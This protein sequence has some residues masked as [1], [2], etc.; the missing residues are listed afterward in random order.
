M[1]KYILITFLLGSLNWAQA[2]ELGKLTVDKI[3]R[4]PV[5]MGTSPSGVQWSA[6]S[7]TVYFQWNP[8]GASKSSWYYITTANTNPQKLSK[9]AEIALPSFRGAFNKAKTQKL[10]E[11]NGDIFL[12]DIKSGK[13]KQIT[14]TLDRESGADF[15]TNQTSIVYQ[16]GDNLYE[17]SLTT[18]E[19]VQLTNFSRSKKRPEPKLNAQEKWLKNEQLVLFDI[20]KKDDAEAKEQK[21]E[22]K[23]REVKRPKEIGID[24]AF[25]NGVQLSPNGKFV[26]YRL[27]KRA[28]GKVADVPN[29]ID[30]SGFTT[31][32]PTRTKV[33]A[34]QSTSIAYVYDLDRDTSYVINTSTIA[35]IKDL[36][37]YVKDYPK[38]L[39]ERQ[40]KNEDREV[41]VGAPI[42]NLAG[43]KA[44]LTVSSQDN[45]D[46]WIMALNPADGSLTLLDRQRDEAWIGGP[47][48]GGSYGGGNIGW[49][50]ESHIYF[51]S[52]ASG[53]SHIYTMDVNTKA[54]KQLTTGNWEVQSLDLS[55][56]KKSFY[57]TANTDH[58]GITHYYKISVNGGEPVKLTSMKGGN[59]VSLSPDE[60]YLADLYSYSNKPWELYLQSNKAGAEAKKITHSTTKEFESYA[61]RDPEMIT[62]NNRYGTK[63]YARLYQSA[64]PDPAKPAVVFVHGAGYLQNVHY[65]WSSYFREYMFHNLLADNG[66]TVLDIDYTGS[67]GYG[68]DFRTGIYRHMGGKDLTDQVDGVKLLVDKYGIN[69]KNIGIY[70]GSY[71]GFITLMAMFTQPDVFAA[72]AGLR[73]VTDWAHYNHGYTANI[74]NEP[75]N[76]EKAYEMSSPINFADGLKGHLLMC[77]G[78][79]DLNVHFQDIVRL[80]QRLIELKK[81][82]W[83]LAV[84]PVE[85]HGF[86]QPTSWRDEYSRIFKL[87]QENLKAKN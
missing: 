31:N 70:G 47:G 33:G 43:T 26:T 10:Y 83:E 65:Q 78:M 37:D 36:P 30:D 22:A 75:Y 68:R 73:S 64:N 86:E 4:D 23:F 79:L 9:E 11:K 72:G 24:D 57:F 50:D 74:L 58:P 80:S 87:F 21:I 39:A 53:Y 52:E 77:H 5:W 27:I 13:S 1:K 17:Q 82:N 19:L 12:L 54:K 55:N 51:Q 61:W 69:P 8:E 32:I 6:D 56:D 28:D 42:W 85:N 76:D 60:K 7:K 35:G 25:V 20:I 14:N 44:V 84:F 49:F 67:S 15:S 66:Y 41:T 16:K 62:F 59:D 46:R 45:K 48:I 81:D 34:A 3:M 29:Y 18:G 71:G 40:K 38:Q 2:Q 63:V